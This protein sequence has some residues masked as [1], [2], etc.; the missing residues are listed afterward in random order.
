MKAHNSDVRIITNISITTTATNAIN[1]VIIS[2][3][4]VTIILDNNNKNLIIRHKVTH[5]H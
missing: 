1:N 2:D 3:I 4:I 5:N